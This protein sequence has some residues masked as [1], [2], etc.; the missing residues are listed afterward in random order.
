MAK[1]A[2]GRRNEAGGVWV[3]S[4]GRSLISLAGKGAVSTQPSLLTHLPTPLEAPSA[5]FLPPTAMADPSF[6]VG[7]VG[8]VISILVFA[9]PIG[10]FWRV[11]KKKS[12]ENFKGLPYV[13]TLLS[14]SLWTFYGLLKPGGLLVVTVNGTGSVLQA[15]Y[16]TLFLMYA[17]KDVKVKTARLVALLNVGFLGAVIL[18]TRLAIHGNMRLLVVGSMCSALTVGMYASAMAAMRTVVK[19]KSVEY[20]PFSLSFFLFL[21]GGIWLVYAV[22]VRDHF[23]GVPTAI[24]F[25]LGS[26]Q[27]TL[28]AMY[29]RRQA[30]PPKG[31]AG[32]QAGEEEEGWSHIVRQLEMG[33]YGNGDAA[34]AAQQRHL[35]KGRSLPKLSV[36]HQQ[37]LTK[38]ARSVSL[39][40]NELHSHCHQEP[41]DAKE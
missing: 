2:Q 39:S 7:V 21:N 29:Y 28:Y 8:N 5:A 3:G 40:P 36:P 6:A 16:V 20:M 1:E 26:L 32:G 17:P 18:V 23:I 11:F 12:T 31:A 35:N 24:G 19:T 33:E 30:P 38:I 4:R 14:T 13:I 10:T 25:V 15:A 22:L 9:S 41:V 34:A 37:S 27:L